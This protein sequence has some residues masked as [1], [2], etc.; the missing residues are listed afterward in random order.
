MTMLAR[1]ALVASVFASATLHAASP[2]SGAKVY[3][4][5][6]V[7]VNEYESAMYDYLLGCD[8]DAAC[9][10]DA[11]T[12]GGFCASGNCELV[13][14]LD[15]TKDA[16]RAKFNALA[17][18]AKAGDTVL[19]YQSSHGDEYDGY[20]GACLCMA[21]DTWRDTEFADD[22]AK[23]ADGVRVVVVLDAC[24]SGGMFKSAS[25]GAS[26]RNAAARWDFAAG[27]QRSLEMRR[28]VATG[29]AAT[30]VAAKGTV[31]KG[32]PA[33]AWMTAADWDE[34]S[35]MDER[36]SEFTHAILRGWRDGSADTD[37]DGYVSFGELAE[38]AKREVRDSSVQ[39]DNYDLLRD[40]LAG[41]DYDVD[42]F[43]LLS[44]GNALYGFLGE[45]PASVVVPV[46]TKT[47]AAGAFDA[48]YCDASA[49]RS[50]LVPDGVTDIGYCAFAFCGSL[51]SASLPAQFR[52]RLDRSV[53]E[54]CPSDLVVDYRVVPTKCR[55]TFGKNGGTG[56]DDY[57]TATYGAAMPT[58]RTAPK[59]AGWTFGG[60]WDTVA[61]DERG[62]P[63]GRQ[64]YNASMKSV[65]AWDKKGP[66]TLWAK[67]TVRVTLGKNGGTGG[68]EYVT[69][70]FNQP[71]P[72]RT[73]PK[74]PGYAF[75]G[76]WMSSN[77]R[78][79]QCYDEDGTGTSAMRWMTGGAPAIWA[80][81]TK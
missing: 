73:M 33:V 56:G 14:N 31:A 71:F 10:M 68:D 78:I 57:V 44:Y 49:L 32:I 27:V 58:P 50:V 81:W 51:A 8:W 43:R 75:G 48:E 69:A 9:M 72:K 67:W 39:I 60:Y 2:P 16:V 55:V 40:V 17:N 79:G 80:L 26:A 18:V 62:N 1:F 11:Y 76:Y 23:F 5:L 28:A 61:M 46:G 7:G 24:H 41:R 6:F 74:K 13:A 65:R 53:F 34:Y 37:S 52:G 54:G 30:G 45:C 21:D 59:R 12:R 66:A 25:V 64:Y 20:K 36:G 35:W 19:Y 70:T 77:N 29:A 47:I 22:L 3:Y 15:A 4:G 38:Y 42:T 63:K